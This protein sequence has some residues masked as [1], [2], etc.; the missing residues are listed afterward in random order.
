MG[1]PT[2]SQRNSQKRIWTH[3]DAKIPEDVLGIPG[4]SSESPIG[5]PKDFHRVPWDS[6]GLGVRRDFLGVPRICCFARAMQVM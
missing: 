5:I 6:P 4:D 3:R 1:I 2:G